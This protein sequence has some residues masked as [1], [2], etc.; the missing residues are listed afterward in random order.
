MKHARGMACD[1][2][3]GWGAALKHPEIVRALS[4]P[5]PTSVCA[6]CHVQKLAQRRAALELLAPQQRA[7]AQ[8]IHPHGLKL[9]QLMCANEAGCFHSEEEDNPG[10]KAQPDPDSEAQASAAAAAQTP[11]AASPATLPC[12]SERQLTRTRLHPFRSSTASSLLRLLG[13]RER[14]LDAQQKER[15]RISAQKAKVLLASADY[16]DLVERKLLEA[17]LHSTAVAHALPRGQQRNEVRRTQNTHKPHTKH[18]HTHTHI[19]DA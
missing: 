3:G 6:V 12:P 11:P 4:C 14:A 2:E 7:A 10:Y 8:V 13:A 18:T 9:L 19:T 15:Q 1:W 16:C 17:V 5:S